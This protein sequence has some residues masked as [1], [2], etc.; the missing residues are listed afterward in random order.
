MAAPPLRPAPGTGAAGARGDPLPAGR[1]RRLV[2]AAARRDVAACADLV[3]AFLPRI[4]AV[5]A[6]F[7]AA[8][9]VGRAELVQEGVAGLLLATRHYD[10]ARRT[11]F[12]PYASFWVRKAMQELLAEL[13]RP[14]ALSDRAVRALAAVRAAH[15]DHLHA[16]GAA[17][18]TADLSRATGLSRAQVEALQGTERAARSVHEPADPHGGRDT[19]GDR[20]PDPAA[21]QAY[22]AVLDRIELRR[23]Q[24]VTARLPDRERAVVRAHFGLGEPARTLGRIAAELGVTAERVRQIEAGALATLRAAMAAPAPP[25]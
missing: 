5:A 18:T 4:T 22:D 2:L 8:G 14:V 16:R 20:V 23:L 3:T 6:S 13:T 24:E 7:P 25:G 17:P 1:E 21:E 10:P 19:V 15:L 9:G 11:P 12:W